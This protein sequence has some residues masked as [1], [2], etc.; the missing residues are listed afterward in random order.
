MAHHGN[1]AQ[2]SLSETVQFSEA[3]DV[4]KTLTSEEDTL[5]VVTSDHSH[6]FTAGGY[7]ARGNNILGIAGNGRDG[8][9]YTALSYANG[10]GYKKEENEARHDFS[11]YDFCEYN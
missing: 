11:Q 9:P 6:V 1:L 7:P 2:K 4:A 5:I 8:I 10:P 3:I